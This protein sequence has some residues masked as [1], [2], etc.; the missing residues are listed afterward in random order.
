MQVRFEVLGPLRMWRGGAEADLGPRQQQLVLALLLARAGRPATLAELVDLLWDD[1]PPASAVNV[2]HRYV[3]LVR[4]CLEPDLP[5][6]AAGRWLSRQPGGYRL[7]VDARSLDLLRFRE[8]AERGRDA[9]ERQEWAPA[10]ASWQEACGLWHGPFAAGLEPSGPARLEFAAADHEFLQAA[11]AFAEAALHAGRP[12][13]AL[14]TL[15][16]VVA[17]APLDEALQA[18]LMLLLAAAGQPAAAIEAFHG[19]RRRLAD[20]LAVEPGAELQEAY[21]QVLGR[22]GAGGAAPPRPAQLPADLPFFTGREAMLDELARFAADPAQRLPVVAI[23]GMPGVGKTTLAVHLAHR[24]AGAYPDGQLYVNLRGFDQYG[25]VLDPGD[26]LRQ[27]L[28]ALGEPPENASAGRPELA[29][30]FRSALA[31]RRALIVLDNARDTEHVVDLLPGAPGALVIITS[32]NQLTGLRATHGAELA[33]LEL[34]SADE[35]RRCLRRQLGARHHPDRGTLDQ[36]ADRCGRLPLALTLVG[37]RAAAHPTFA[38]GDVAAELGTMRE[39]EAGLGSAEIGN[40][41]RNVFDYSYRL[42]SPAAARVFRLLALHPRPE[43]AAP[44][45][46]SLAAIPLAESRRLLDELISTRLLFETR[47][48]RYSWHDLIW[49]YATE[50]G[51]EEPADS[52]QAA[53]ARI[54]QHFWH[55]AYRAN[56][57][58]LPHVLLEAPDDRPAGVLPE[59]IPDPEAAIAWFTARRRTLLAA[60]RQAAQHGHGELAWRLAICLQ[61]FFERAYLSNDWLD[62]ME[63]AADAAEAVGDRH[64]R[65]YVHRSI[66]GA[67]CR[68][69][70][71]D[72]AARE[73]DQARSLFEQFGDGNGEAVTL[74][75]L[76]TVRRR[77]RRHAEA[78]KHA[79][80]ARQR[81][82]AVGNRAGEASALGELA[83]ILTS[84]GEMTRARQM[85]TQ[86]IAIY[87]DLGDIEREAI[88]VGFLAE[89]YRATGD[90]PTALGWCRRAVDLFL[91]RGSLG[92]AGAQLLELGD[93]AAQAGD[94]TAAVQAWRAAAEYLADTGTPEVHEIRSRL[95]FHNLSTTDP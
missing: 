37:A 32:R 84:T 9:A 56:A 67:Y 20:D 61:G 76:A 6:R 75:N 55:T 73:L 63:V 74:F 12:A 48:G 38:L 85:V 71:H 72:Q 15:R 87:R 16:A 86:S 41:L 39:G 22:P 31:G 13:S 44:D 45:V 60:I 1:D 51:E 2:V 26:V 3:G 28:R 5:P 25:T 52:R 81:L 8:L 21:R 66:A 17:R 54:Y 46:A 47:P 68:L 33:T 79:E 35:A 23:D 80:E 53:R 18:R 93:L 19:V 88:S 82:R 30:L 49:T 59:V 43:F 34:F 57:L 58:L 95:A 10:L 4:R 11:A 14:P 91:R 50:L 7:D 94:T 64:G 70:N 36:I 27:F 92:R 29:G 89:T 65:A 83:R 90:Y 62:I 69:G 40:D 42:L 78:L 77:Q 24:L